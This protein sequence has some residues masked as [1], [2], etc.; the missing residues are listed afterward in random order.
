MEIEHKKIGA[1]ATILFEELMGKPLCE[2]DRTLE[3][4]LRFAF[5]Y[6]KVKENNKLSFSAWF[7]FMDDNPD[8]L[9]NLLVE[10]K[11]SDAAEIINNPINIK[12]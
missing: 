7:E 9:D 10:I 5:C 3:N 12:I 11:N 1:E 6:Q 4:M 8:L 2:I